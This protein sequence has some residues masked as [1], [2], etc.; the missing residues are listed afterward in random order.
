MPFTFNPKN[1]QSAGVAADIGKNASALDQVLTSA[2]QQE[3]QHQRGVTTNAAA[4]KDVDQTVH[5]VKEE[6][7]HRPAMDL[8]KSIFE[9]P[10]DDDEDEDDESLSDENE[11]NNNRDPNG[12]LSR[13]KKEGHDDDHPPIMNS[14]NG[15]SGDD[16]P[17]S[18]SA[19][20]LPLP[21]SNVVVAAGE[22]QRSA[23]IQIDKGD[24][25]AFEN[26]KQYSHVVEI[27]GKQTMDNSNDRRRR[28]RDRSDRGRARRHED[29]HSRCSYSSSDDD[30]DND[31]RR[32]RRRKK[33]RHK[34]KEHKK[35]SRKQHKKNSSRRKYSTD[36]DGSECT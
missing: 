8:F 7:V 18:E 21:M 15:Y 31:D 35:R 14:S 16:D 32:R 10:D 11:N 12:L 1:K 26:R 17:R 33:K 9:Q 6:A 30:D 29:R 22:Q 34:Q 19:S 5:D 28:K 3:Q 20:A 13:R 27:E 36:D 23:M 25:S 2:L 24:G 4:A